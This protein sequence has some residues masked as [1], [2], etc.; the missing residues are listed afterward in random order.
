MF[1]QHFAKKAQVILKVFLW[2]D[3][4]RE[5]LIKGDQISAVTR[6]DLGPENPGVY[7]GHNE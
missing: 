4:I 6:I 2:G 5:N 7:S 1:A 3:Q